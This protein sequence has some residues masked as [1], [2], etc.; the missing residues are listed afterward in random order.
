MQ[1]TEHE[2]R[3]TGTNIHTHIQKEPNKLRQQANDNDGVENS[4]YRFN[5]MHCTTHLHTLTHI[6]IG[7]SQAACISVGLSVITAKS[8]TLC[9]LYNSEFM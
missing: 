8:R 6:S 1:E 7:V 2:H 9:H 4:S 3:Q 5:I